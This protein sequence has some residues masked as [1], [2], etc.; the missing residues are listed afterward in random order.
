MLNT[1]SRCTFNFSISA[2][3]AAHLSAGSDAAGPRQVESAE[4]L[5]AALVVAVAELA[6]IAPSNTPPAATRPTV[7]AT[8]FFILFTILL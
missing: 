4:G 8:L 6:A 1:A 5:G 2:L 3:N 7:P